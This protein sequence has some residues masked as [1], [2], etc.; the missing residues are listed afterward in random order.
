MWVKSK[1]IKR[2]LG[3]STQVL[4]ED[5]VIELKKKKINFIHHLM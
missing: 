4:G 3:L 1:D 2:I 5:I